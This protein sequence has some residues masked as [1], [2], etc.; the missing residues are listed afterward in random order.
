MICFGCFAVGVLVVNFFTSGAL[1]WALVLAFN[2]P[3]W[4]NL[5]CPNIS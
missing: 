5:G 1:C 2:N 3:D 4:S